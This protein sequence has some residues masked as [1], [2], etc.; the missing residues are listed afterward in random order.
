[1]SDHQ[2]NGASSPKMWV[3]APALPTEPEDVLL[4]WVR[5]IEAA[6]FGREVKAFLILNGP[7][8][9]RASRSLGQN[10]PR[11]VESR[12]L[13]GPASIGRAQQII[14]HQ[15]LQ[16]EAQF[17][18]RIDPDGQ[19]PVG[20]LMELRNCLTPAGPD[21]IVAQRDEASV[22]GYVRFLANVVLRL[23]ALRLGTVADPNAGCY[24]M[25]RRAAAALCQVPLPKYPEPRMLMALKNASLT[26]SS[27]VVPT[28]PRRHGCSS[29][30]GLAQAAMV[31]LSSLL[32]FLTW[33]D[34]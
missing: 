30:R 10:M 21:V 28:L 33:N 18:A 34:L 5:E 4:E 15:F 1:M 24:I 2:G 20:C 7:S 23:V 3:W 11:S 14:M 25:N 26:V 16:S 19:F 31:F 17:L 9:E 8:S 29:I 12:W 32:E 6:V 13:A 27:R 22:C